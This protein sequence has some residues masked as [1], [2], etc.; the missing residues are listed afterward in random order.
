MSVFSCVLGTDNRVE[1][2]MIITQLTFKS[3]LLS[4]T[5]KLKTKNNKLQC[6]FKNLMAVSV[7]VEPTY[8]RISGYG[9]ANRC[10]YH[11]ANSP[12]F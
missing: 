7:G 9:L 11:S 12:Y 6:A 4:W 5:V 2:R 1:L 10:I 3:T 8:L